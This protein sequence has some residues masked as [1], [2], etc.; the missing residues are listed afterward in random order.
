MVKEL[1]RQKDVSC[2]FLA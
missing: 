2:P 1:K